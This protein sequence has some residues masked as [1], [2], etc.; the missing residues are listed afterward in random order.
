MLQHN[1]DSPVVDLGRI[2]TEPKTPNLDSHYKYYHIGRGVC[3]LHLTETAL[4][5]QMDAK[6]VMG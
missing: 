5:C 6:R 4:I 3:G 1:L 2:S